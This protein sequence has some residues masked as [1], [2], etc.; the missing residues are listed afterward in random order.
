MDLME[1]TYADVWCIYTNDLMQI[2]NKENEQ[3]R[4]FWKELK[5]TGDKPG[6][7]SNHRAIGIESNIYVYGGLINNENLKNTMYW[8]DTNNNTWHRHITKVNI[9]IS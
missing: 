7:L 1:D 3:N 6:K 8:F 4:N 9:E 5:T 2:L